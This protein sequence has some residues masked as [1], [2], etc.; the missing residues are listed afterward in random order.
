MMT[1]K[2]FL[3][4]IQAIVLVNFTR[5]MTLDSYKVCLIEGLKF[6]LEALAHILASAQLSLKLCL[7]ACHAAGVLLGHLMELMT[8]LK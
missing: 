7:K 6:L 8:L 1:G 4:Q 3:S 5:R 2:A